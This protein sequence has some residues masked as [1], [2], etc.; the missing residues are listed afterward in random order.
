V[1]YNPGHPGMQ[2]PHYH[3]IE[4]LITPAQQAED[5]K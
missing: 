5:L 1:N 3:F 2:E 4:W